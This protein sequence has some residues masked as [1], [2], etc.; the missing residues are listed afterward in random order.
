MEDDYL[1]PGEVEAEAAL[2]GPPPFQEKKTV[3]K[4]DNRIMVWTP[5]V[6]VMEFPLLCSRQRYVSFSEENSEVVNWRAGK[7]GGPGC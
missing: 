3:L 7:V 1:V 2:S 5:G 4:P 6:Q